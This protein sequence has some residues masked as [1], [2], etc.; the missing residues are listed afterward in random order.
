MEKTEEFVYCSSNEC[1]Y[2]NNLDGN[3]CSI[4]VGGYSNLEDVTIEQ[5]EKDFNEMLV[6]GD[7]ECDTRNRKDLF[8]FCYAVIKGWIK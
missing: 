4:Y 7:K 5:I 6:L 1:V 3:E 2:Y 8:I